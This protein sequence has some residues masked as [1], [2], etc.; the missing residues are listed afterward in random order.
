[1]F[2]CDKDP[3]SKKSIEANWKPVTFYPDIT[4]R[5]NSISPEVDL[6]TAGFPCQSFSRAGKQEGFYDAKGNGTIFHYV[7]D[8]IVKTLPK[9]FVL[10][11]VDGIVTIDEGECLRVIIKALESIK[12]PLGSEITK[13]HDRK[14]ARLPIYEIHWK[15]LNA[16]E[17]G[18]PQSRRRWYCIGLRKDQFEG[19][20]TGK[21]SS[22]AW[23]KNI[24]CPPLSDF[25]DDDH[26]H[27]K[28]H[29][30]TQL[31][32][33]VHR[34]IQ[35]AQLKLISEGKDP[36]Q[37]DY[38]IDCFRSSAHFHNL[39][40]CITRS[41]D[42]GHWIT[43]RNRLFNKQEMFRL[44]GMDPTKFKVS[45]SQKS[46]GQQIGNA[47]S[48]N[49]VE[50][51]IQSTLKAVG[52]LDQAAPDRWATG[53]ALSQLKASRGKT[54]YKLVKN[55]AEG[56]R[57]I[58][59]ELSE[60]AASPAKRPELSNIR[61]I[62]DT[63]ASLHLVDRKSL[64]GKQQQRVRKS[65]KEIALNI[66]N[67]LV[68][69][70]DVID[71]YIKELNIN[72]TAHVLENTVPV[73]SMGLLVKDHNFDFI[74][75]KATGPY[76][77]KGS[78]P[79]R[80]CFE[81]HDVPFI[82]AAYQCHNIEDG[83]Q[84]LEDITLEEQSAIVDIEVKDGQEFEMDTPPAT[85]NLEPI[86]PTIDYEDA[87]LDEEILA[88]HPEVSSRA[89]LIK[90]MEEKLK[91]LKKQSRN[92]AKRK[93]VTCTKSNTHNIFTHFPFDPEC[94]I[95]QHNKAHRAYCKSVTTPRVD[96]QPAPT[97]FAEA[98]TADHKILNKFD[99]SRDHDRA[100]L[101]IQDKA[102]YW[103]QGF[104]AP[105]KNGK[106]TQKAL[107]KFVG[108]GRKNVH[109]Y[110]DNSKE[111]ETACEAMDFQHDCSQ[112][113]RSE[114]NGLIE[115]AVKRVNQGTSC[116]LSQSGLT[117][118][119]WPQAMAIYCFFR[120]NVDV[121]TCGKTA[122]EQRFDEPFKGKLI[123]L[124]AE[125][126][127]VP[128]SPAD[129]ER[130][131]KFGPKR[132]EGIF[133]GYQQEHGG[134]WNKQ[135]YVLDSEELENADSPSDIHHRQV[136]ISELIVK[137]DEN[138]KHCFPIAEGL[139][140]QPGVGDR[141]Q[142]IAERRAEKK[143]A[144]Q[145]KLEETRRRLKEEEERRAS[146]PAEQHTVDHDFWTVS[147]DL[148]TRHHKVPRQHLYTPKQDEFPMPFEYIDIFRTTRT[149]LETTKE[150]TVQDYWTTDTTDGTKLSNYWKGATQFQVL[151]PEPK[152][153]HKWVNGIEVRIQTTSRPDNVDQYA[154]P[155]MN[156]IQKAEAQAQW[157][158]DGPLMEAERVKTGKRHLDPDKLDAFKAKLAEL[159]A[160][161]PR[162]VVPVMPTIRYNEQTIEAMAGY[163]LENGE[164]EVRAKNRGIVP[165]H[166]TDNGTESPPTMNR[167]NA[168]DDDEFISTLFDIFPKA[169]QDKL[170]EK[171]YGQPVTYAQSLHKGLSQ[172]NAQLRSD[173]TFKM[174]TKN[175]PK[176]VSKPRD[177]IKREQRIGD[178]SEELMAMIHKAIPIDQAYK[179]KEASDAVEAEW[180]KLEKI[181]SWD[182]DLVQDRRDVVK[183]SKD[184][185]IT[186]HFGSLRPL[187]HQ[188]NSEQSVEFRSYKGRVIFRG[189]IVRDEDGAYAVFTEQGTSASHSASTKIIDA[190]AHMP[191]MAGS[192]A[193]A[194]AAYT[195]IKL[196]DATRLLG[197]GTVPET[198]ITLPRARW[199]QSW[200]DREAKDPLFVPVCPLLR[201]LYGHPLAGLLWDKGSQEKILSV[202]FEKVP[203]WESLYI[204][205]KEKLILGV[206][207]DDFHLSGREQSIAPMWEKLERAGIKL[208][209]A[210]PFNHNTYLGC[211][212]HDVEISEATVKAKTILFD[213]IMKQASATEAE[214]DA[215][216]H[217]KTSSGK[218]PVKGYEYVMAG[219]CE[220]CVERYLELAKKP[221]S[222][223]KKVATPC[224]DD[225]LIPPEDFETKGELAKEASKIVLKA[226][227]C[228]RLARLD[229][230][231]TVNSLAREVTK[232]TVA[233]DKRLHR[234]MCYINCTKD[235]VMT[236]HVGDPLEDC[237]L[238]MFVDASFAGDL[239][240]SKSTTGVI[241]VL[242][243]P[244]TFCPISWICKKQGAISHSS[245]EAEII[246]LDAGLRMEGIPLVSLWELVIDTFAP[247]KEA[248][249][250]GPQKEA[251]TREVASTHRDPLNIDYVPPSIPDDSYLWK[252]R[253]KLVICEDNDAVITMCTKGRS[254]T[255]RH[256]L[257]VHRVDLDTLWER[258]RTDPSLSMRYV[259]TK[260]QLADI[261]TKGS[262]TKTVWD[263]LRE[264]IQTGP[265][266]KKAPEKQSKLCS[267]VAH[268]AT[269]Q[270]IEKC[271]SDL[272]ILRHCANVFKRQVH[273]HE[274]ISCNSINELLDS[275][276]LLAPAFAA[277]AS[278]HYILPSGSNSAP[279]VAPSRSSTPNTKLSVSTL[280]K[281]SQTQEKKAKP[282]TNWTHDSWSQN[283][284]TGYGS[285][286]HEWQQTAERAAIDSKEDN[287]WTS[288]QEEAMSAWNPTSWGKQQWNI[289]FP[290]P[291]V[292]PN[293]GKEGKGYHDKGHG[294]VHG[295]AKGKGQGDDQGKAKGE[296]GKAYPNQG[297]PGLAKGA[298][299]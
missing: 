259:G 241:M 146:D 287:K 34:N 150:K 291:P 130:C 233:C 8:Y 190:I 163:F 134:G 256:V 85:D 77:Q 183:R 149:D 207:V 140:K 56:E 194:K 49:V 269:G 24:P 230:L 43:S 26:C 289:P 187:C 86:P 6:Y 50:R 236:S 17:N 216:K 58:V 246:A 45:I 214:L 27:N 106:E 204:H 121:H 211:T 111:I 267:A 152:S 252:H 199:P 285:W 254:T 234:L 179:I 137:L 162:Q 72:I 188:K 276:P 14:C 122:Y 244:R 82:V 239:R 272:A 89:E 145:E 93:K 10:E 79:K 104:P 57:R 37:L 193:D 293:K 240:D 281:Q 19:G 33:S 22:F 288:N 112:P 120:N 218:H 51:V 70:S 228:A 181:K 226:L 271:K 257:R 16:K 237:R 100:A 154:W 224:I 129:K 5:D 78:E 284:N 294:T 167:N 210:V 30:S 13:I 31:S 71:L 195:Q 223:L 61:F 133:E 42:R 290:P 185:S 7:H 198:W 220:G 201:N 144:R 142:K 94:E 99:E 40:P 186:V 157:L 158:I 126:T 245:T 101:I 277:P 65:T 275:G 161:Y 262:F 172:M 110:S 165:S 29:N 44:Q 124:G 88:D 182:V 1:M 243:G 80:K 175:A 268:Q 180:V 173:Q 177:H 76:L 222:Y 273:R 231:W 48:V 215:S 232:W 28:P 235:D 36:N 242:V 168:F 265:G 132:L 166:P 103:L 2:A 35:K 279:C 18:T 238:V 41:R 74:W 114:T 91:M 270:Q 59:V 53:E 68:W 170:D 247:E 250:N 81:A 109:V 138:G 128:H 196:S 153:N 102:T 62:A 90:V 98:L 73:L 95:C 202:G 225:Q 280:T 266:Y 298:E 60:A 203:Q 21:K 292:Q 227:Y 116:A 278:L 189:D 248:K 92:Q 25:L 213:H 206:Y 148:I 155:K 174:P 119:W 253:A 151:R 84:S 66:A 83:P 208:D 209:P 63:G 38:V 20:L 3:D 176:H 67:G 131:H 249:P 96:A 299:K 192:D 23:P 9:V 125:V 295:G 229:L 264:L 282:M 160:Q 178:I 159:Q 127:Y 184:K 118:Y 191:G 139:L 212:Q 105:A 141:E 251:N 217:M 54:F 258:L 200:L 47:M 261:L 12:A 205:K 75:R 32:P 52:L 171:R 263:E 113:Y 135:V 156:P 255:M 143:L 64:S 97:E 46:L 169:A 39:S 115:N 69:S 296:K 164:P 11:N 260:Q 221:R 283:T 108:R 286:R 297:S 147:G 197:V 117:T 4:T 123:P 274:Q 219:A 107:A 15:V 136:P 87:I 55:H